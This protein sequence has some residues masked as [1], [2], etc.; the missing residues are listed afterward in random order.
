MSEYYDAQVKKATCDPLLEMAGVLLPE[1]DKLRLEPTLFLTKEGLSIGL[2]IGVDRMYVV[3]NIPHFIKS[4]SSGEITE[5]GKGFELNPRLMT[6]SE[7]QMKLIR[8]LEEYCDALMTNPGISGADAR[9]LLLKPLTAARVLDLLKD[10]YFRLQIKGE[11]A[12]FYGIKE[13]DLPIVS[14]LSGSLQKIR[15]SIHL[16][17]P[18]YRLTNDFSYV[19][20]GNQISHVNQKQQNL[21]QTLAG[22][23]QGG[24]AVFTYTG[25]DVP[26]FLNEVLPLLFGCSTV[27][28]DEEIACRLVKRPLNARI[29]LDKSGAIITARV[30]FAYGN[31]QINPFDTVQEKHG[32]ILLRDIAGENQ[33][34][35]V[36]SRT[37]FRVT[38]SMVY[39]DQPDAIWDFVTEGV[40]TLTGIAEVFFSKEFKKLTPRKPRFS[41]KMSVRNGRIE[42][43]L[44]DEHEEI[45]ELLPLM[46][47]LSEKRRYFR[48]KSGI[49]IDLTEQGEWQA[50][51]EAIVEANEND[52]EFRPL[53]LC[54]ASYL[55]AL[56]EQAHLPI[57]M[58]EEVRSV[59]SLK[60]QAPPPP[61]EGLREYQKRG[62]EWLM[63]LDALK[64]GGILADDMGLGKTVQMISAIA[65]YVQDTP[66]H[67]PSLIVA[68][69]TLLFNWLSE[70]G[71]FAPH[72][73]VEMIRG[74]QTQRMDTLYRISQKTP[75]VIITSYPLIRRDIDEIEKIAFRFAVLDE[76]QQIKNNQSIGAHA[77]KRLNAVTKIALTGT[78]MENH[79]GELWSI[80]DFCLPGY[81]PS[82]PKFLKKYGDGENIPDLQKRIRPFLMRRIKSDVLNELPDLL[83]NTLYAEL[84]ADQKKTYDAVMLQLSDRVDDILR[85]KGMQK[86]RAEVLSAITQLRQICCDPVLCLPGYEGGS[87]KTDLLMDVLPA[88]IH[89]GSRVL[90]FSQFTS[91]LKILEKKLAD[92]G[93]NTLYLDG[94]TPAEERLH[95]TERFNGGEGD[96][97]L[98]SLKAGGTG[99]NLTGADMV[100]HYDPWWNP[101]ALDQ[102]TGRA[103]RIGQ[104][105]AVTVLS[106]VT[107]G[108]IEEQVVNMS[109]RKRQL[110][111]KLITAGEALP[112]A[113]TDQ[114]ILSLFGK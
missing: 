50:L 8:V 83:E 75:D 28:M 13:E 4:L 59:S 1:T 52:T 48:F 64:M 112:T 38:R 7:E 11:N 71:R 19:L 60:Y 78:P 88:A 16:P 95:L 24:E 86:G 81:L 32:E 56:I 85:S 90:L 65:R 35:Q 72:L 79:T 3:R 33:I 37:G 23:T 40:N 97:F 31:V 94:E 25:E 49:F 61:F 92:A 106:L 66:Q 43:H 93:L 76:A 91:M 77:V 110:F 107:H 108:T 22:H 47:A 111:D 55:N 58:D 9:V 114:D 63:T 2:R 21:I 14:R 62:Y 98:I 70:F 109:Q 39:L 113:L 80:M 18:M 41:G 87:G 42:L 27:T 82:Y 74:S 46:R 26:R 6:L 73:T 12:E 104:T 57:E 101:T 99:L 54:R 68:P 84:T 29:Y 103:H 69:T 20:S 105:H 102:A 53:A 45:D 15:V 17:Y 34:M 30:N 5:F 44:M 96:V 10:S 36:L 51:A 100:I 67:L 89:S